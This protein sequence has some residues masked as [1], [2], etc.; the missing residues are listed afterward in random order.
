MFEDVVVA[1]VEGSKYKQMGLREC[2]KFDFENKLREKLTG[3]G[4]ICKDRAAKGLTRRG[5]NKKR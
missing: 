1:P 3:W 4:I 5:K 2:A